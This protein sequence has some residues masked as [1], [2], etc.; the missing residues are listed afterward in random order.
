MKIFSLNNLI[1]KNILKINFKNSKLYNNKYFN[2]FKIINNLEYARLCL[3]IKKK[4]IKLSNDRNRLKRIFKYSFC[5][6]QFLLP[7]YDFI[8]FLKK[9]INNLNNYK[10]FKKIEKIWKFKNY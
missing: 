3:I 9:P 4:N 1:I 8:F 10:I 5:Y 7:L 2:I 6:N